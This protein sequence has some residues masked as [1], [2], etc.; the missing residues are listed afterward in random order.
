M[1]EVDLAT[2]KEL[3]GH[4]EDSPAHRRPWQFQCLSHAAV[5]AV[6]DGAT[7]DRQRR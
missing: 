5:A 6:A 4:S 1:V 2:R 7:G 3:N